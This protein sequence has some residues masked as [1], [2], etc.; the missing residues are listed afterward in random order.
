MDQETDFQRSATPFGLKMQTKTGLMQRA[1]NVQRRSRK[2]NDR[3]KLANGDAAT[4]T[5]AA[6]TE[7]NSNKGS[8]EAGSNPST[9]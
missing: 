1:A 8:P 5:N 6:L 2:E 7:S 9:P 3:I 4:I